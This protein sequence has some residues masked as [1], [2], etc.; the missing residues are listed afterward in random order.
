[1]FVHG[2]DLKL[3]PRFFCSFLSNGY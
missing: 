2:A 3:A 1:M